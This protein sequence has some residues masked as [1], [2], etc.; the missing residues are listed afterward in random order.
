MHE[1]DYS[2]LL[3]F[4]FFYLDVD[5]FLRVI[6]EYKRRNPTADFPEPTEYAPAVFRLCCN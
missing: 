2:L 1:D 6:Q 5:E 3:P 4:V